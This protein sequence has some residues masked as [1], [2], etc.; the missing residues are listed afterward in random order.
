MKENLQRFFNTIKNWWKK[1][2]LQQASRITYDV[3]WNIVLFVMIIGVIGGIFV[4][5]I[6]LG[7]FASLVHDEPLRSEASMAEDIYNYSET[8]SIYFANDVYLGDIRSDL[9]REEVKLD[10]ISPTLVNAVI[11]TEDEYFHEHEGVVPKAILRATAQEFLNSSVQTGGSTLTQQLIKNQILTDEVSFDRKAKEILLAMRLE[12]YFTKDEIIEAYL[13]IIP[14][15]RNSSGRN[16][17]GIQTAS[18]GIFGVDASELTLPQAAYLAGLPQGP[19]SYTPFTAEGERK[20]EEDLQPGINRMKTVLNRMHD[21]EYITDEELEEAANYDIAGDFIDAVPSSTD[22]YPYVTY[23]VEKRAKEIIRGLLMEEDGV[24]EEDLAEDDDLRKEYAERTEKEMR[25]GGY[26]IHT[27]IN[28]EMYDAMEEA[29]QNYS[30]YGYAQTYT[31]TNSDGEEYEVTQPIQ[32]GAIM[33]EN[34]TGKI[35]SFVGGRGFDE[36]HQVNFATDTKRSPGSTIKPLLDY[37]PAMEEGVLQPATP[38][39]DYPQSYPD[40]GPPIRNYGGGN[41]GIV[42]ARTALANSYNIPAV[43]TYLKII[44]KDPAAKYLEKMGV[45]SLTESDHTI[46]SLSIGAMDYGMSVEENV[47]AFSTFGNNGK[48][49][50]AYMID[51]ITNAEGDVL[52]EHETEPVEVFSP[53]TTYLTV[54]MMRDVIDNGTAR[55]LNSQLQNT[56]VDWAGKTGTSQDYHDAWFVAT[57]PNVTF[58]TWIGYEKP[59]PIDHPYHLTYS[60]RNMKLWTELINASAKVD[61]VL[62]TPEKRF[63]RPDGIVERSYCAVSG[64]LPS[65]L[66]KEVG[67]VKTD[68]FDSRYV[69]TEKDNS[70]TKGSRL[71]PKSSDDGNSMS[72]GNGIMFNPDWLREEGYD[73]MSDFSMLYPRTETDKWLK[74]GIPASMSSSSSNDEDD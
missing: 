12:N 74:I 61:P 35:L 22:Q 21:M 17:A 67:L 41:Y 44:D 53:Q 50:D 40:G 30:D 63:E 26:Q 43:D 19:S 42:S 66:C 16:I 1:G 54:D 3:V 51:K 57:N 59:A 62:V 18:K 72:K 38:I 32:A 10:N 36:D 28:K 27:T 69:P 9:Y 58:G 34:N 71:V 23:E 70:L 7:Y 2:I 29:A 6:G 5:G 65:D 13:N 31:A 14:Y 46:P 39:A 47:N 4:G 68:L 55:Y 56:N 64:K 8:S 33:V 48:F 73:N 52:Y 49:A 24:T 15:G 60:Q 45:T 20:S 37:A 25:D 11:A